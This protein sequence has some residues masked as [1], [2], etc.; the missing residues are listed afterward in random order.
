MKRM[1]KMTI[2]TGVNMRIAKLHSIM[3]ISLVSK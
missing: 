1:M 3:A 2:S